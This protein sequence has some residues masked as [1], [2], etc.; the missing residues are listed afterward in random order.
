MDLPSAYSARCLSGPVR[1]EFA[2]AGYE[3]ESRE[4]D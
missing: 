1:T 2:V 3:G 4:D